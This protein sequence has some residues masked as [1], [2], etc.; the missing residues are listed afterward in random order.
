MIA[1]Q[2]PDG[3]VSRDLVIKLYATRVEIT[4]SDRSKVTIPARYWACHVPDP[5]DEQGKTR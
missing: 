5:H 4:F 3:T 1:L 2:H